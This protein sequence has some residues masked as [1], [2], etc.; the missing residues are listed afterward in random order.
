MSAYLGG[1]FPNQP[2][3]DYLGDIGQG[4]PLYPPF[5]FRVPAGSDFVLVLTARATNLVCHD[6]ALE[7]FGLP[8]PPPRL[9]I[10]RDS[11]PG[12][13]CVSWSSAYPDYLLQSTNTPRSSGPNAFNDVIAAPVVTSG[14]YTVTNSATPPKESFRLAK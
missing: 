3:A 4:G 7:L 6:Y 1:F 14:R 9:D 5:S 13:V 2:S 12:K 11:A 8:C 10:A